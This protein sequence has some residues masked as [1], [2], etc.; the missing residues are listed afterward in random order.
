MVEWTGVAGIPASE[1]SLVETKATREVLAVAM[2]VADDL[3]AILEKFTYL[4]AM[5]ICPWMR[6]IHN[7]HSEKTRELR[8]PLTTEETNRVTLIWVKRVQN[9]PTTDKH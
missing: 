8:G 7:A 9:R 6:F 4:K 3:D 2:V 5:R 1:K